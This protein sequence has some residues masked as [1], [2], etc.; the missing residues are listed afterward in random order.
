MD[1]TR[2]SY[3]SP[4]PA[5]IPPA[6][7]SRDQWVVWRG[8]QRPGKN[9]KPGKWTKVPYSPASGRKASST[10]RSTWASF[11]AA[12]SRYESGGYDG[13]GF[14]FTKDGPFTGVDFDNCRD[15]QSGELHDWAADYAIGLNTFTEVSPSGTG[16]HAI[17]IGKL[18][19]RGRRKGNVEMYDQ[20]RYFAITGVP[21][22]SQQVDVASRQTE[23]KRL[24]QRVFGQSEPCAP[25]NAPRPADD[26][27][28]LLDRARKARNGAKF[29]LLYDHGDV[30]GH[31][32]ASEADLALCSRLCFWTDGDAA[33]IDTL[34]RSSALMRAKWDESRGERTYGEMTIAK[35]IRSHTGTRCALG[36]Q[37][38]GA[39][40]GPELRSPGRAWHG[41]YGMNDRGNAL[42]LAW[43]LKGK[44][45]WAGES[46]GWL[47]WTGTHWS[48]EP[49][50]ESEVRELIAR[51]MGSLADAALAS[52]GVEDRKQFVSGCGKTSWRR[53]ALSDLRDVASVRTDPDSLDS[54]PYLLTVENGTLDLQTG[55][56]RGHRPEDLLTHCAPV[57]FDPNAKA[58][59]FEKY[60]A[61]VTSGDADLS[62]FLQRVS[63][64]ILV[65]EGSRKTKAFFYLYGP[66]DC[67][68]G[69]LID[70]HRDLL[71]PQLFGGISWGALAA[72]TT[73]GPNSEMAQTESKRLVA[74]PDTG[75]NLRWEVETLKKFTGGDPVTFSEKNKPARTFIPTATLLIAAN[76]RPVVK[77]TGSEAVLV[78]LHVIPFRQSFS[79][80]PQKLETG[81]ALPI[82]RGLK[83]RLLTQ[84]REGIFAW[85]IE[86][87]RRYCDEGLG[88]CAAVE[89]ERGN[90]A[91][92]DEDPLTSMLGV[93]TVTAR[94]TTAPADIES[95][96]VSARDVRHVLMQF[97][98]EDETA[99]AAIEKYVG[100]VRNVSRKLNKLIETDTRFGGLK[101]D[102]KAR[103]CACGDWK[104]GKRANGWGGIAWTDYGHDLLLRTAAPE[105]ALDE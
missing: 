19:P 82:D 4:C 33:R 30:S 68:K 34:F 63:G 91:R 62:A 80:D 20:G 90:W 29:A 46:I 32:S 72:P 59:A 47:R 15:A 81:R 21:L 41:Y 54:R 40:P 105:A 73:G 2:P 75:G 103:V 14:V 25:A 27:G 53:N 61:E 98:E 5:G 84:E 3:L 26:D 78:R 35:A 44:I 18:P 24:H 58:P 70:I 94:D 49:M 74:I 76:D 39:H 66:P 85:M 38:D 51:E 88:T 17:V 95:Q 64:H 57:R 6:L 101:K 52:I 77:G 69:T 100:D 87:A 28:A 37:S 42:R 97:M 1:A 13:V 22:F 11:D 23:L 10:D 86:G 65:G 102:Q 79:S 43:A 56:L 12:W 55:R 8:E 67:G 9:G 36:D 104:R 60:L 93:C 99:P 50:V 16:G 7:R 31:R 45:R 83:E 96:K 48:R 89:A 71:G 92:D